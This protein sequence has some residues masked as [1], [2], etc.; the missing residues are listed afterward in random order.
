MSP[1]RLALR[2]HWPLLNLFVDRHALMAV[3]TCLAVIFSPRP[4]AV[5][6]NGR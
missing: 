6:R 5:K 3:E 4:T 2:R 1:L